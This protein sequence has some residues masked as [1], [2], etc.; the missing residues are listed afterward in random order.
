MTTSQGGSSRRSISLTSSTSQA[1]KKTLENGDLAPDATRKSITSAR[2]MYVPPCIGASVVFAADNF[3][4]W[5]FFLSG[6]SSVYSCYFLLLF[7]LSSMQS[8]ISIGG[9]V[10]LNFFGYS[11]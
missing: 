3:N 8:Y 10:F 2:S 7:L 6:P 1:K 9:Y 11:L 5:F 4:Q